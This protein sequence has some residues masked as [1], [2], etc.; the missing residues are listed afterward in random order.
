MSF[1]YKVEYCNN[2][3]VVTI[4]FDVQVCEGS[5]LGH[6]RNSPLILKDLQEMH[7]IK[8]VSGRRYEIR[9]EKGA[10]FEWSELLP[11]I[12]SLLKKHL[13]KVKGEDGEDKKLRRAVK[14]DGE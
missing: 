13:G 1:R 8:D 10:I 6:D 9:L 4:H 7:G 5:A 2:K 14:F 3:D 11:S 12:I